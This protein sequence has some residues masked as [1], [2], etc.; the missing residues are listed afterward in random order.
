MRVLALA[1]L[2]CAAA[3]APALRA[4]A[5]SR[6][7]VQPAGAITQDPPA[8]KAHPAAMETFQLPS[9]GALLNALVY[10]APGAGPHP[11]VVLLHGFPGNE[12]NLDLAQTLRRAGYDVLFFDYRGSWGTPGDFSLTHCIEDTDAAIAYLRDPKNAQR[13]RADPASIILMGH[14]MGGFLARYAAAHDPA[15]R[16]AVL[17]SAADMGNDRIEAIP[18]A[19]RDRAAAPLAEHLAAEG[20]YPLAG[21]TPQSL[22]AEVIAH[23]DAW[24]LPALGPALASRP[25]L[26][27]TSDDGL[28][29]SNAAVSAA[30]RKAGGTRLSEVHFATDHSYSDHRI[31]LEQA[32]LTFLATLPD[33]KK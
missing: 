23:A 12:R 24:N 17:I 32:I 21:V 8:D 13:L 30:I 16:A 29:P 7:L 26:V 11:A 10:V 25:L 33:A 28:T 6:N 9:H 4:Q 27:I 15:I 19:Y 5:P 1:A 20:M 3:L 14:S 18:A 31:A 22:A 2:A